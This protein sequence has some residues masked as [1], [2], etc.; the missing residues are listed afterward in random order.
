M[1]QAAIDTTWLEPIIKSKDRTAKQG[2]TDPHS[3]R[4]QELLAF[5]SHEVETRAPKRII[6]VERRGTAIL[7]ALKESESYHLKIPW[8]RVISSSVIEQVPDEFYPSMPLLIFDDMKRKGSH[9][10]HVL[11][12]LVKMDP[13]KALL[14]GVRVAVFAMHEDAST[15][16]EYSDTGILNTWFYRGL[17][18]PAYRNMRLSILSML[19]SAGSLMLDTEHLEVRVRLKRPFPEFLEALGRRAD[20]IPFRSLGGRRNVAVVFRDDDPAHVIP[21]DLLP[22]G[23]RT[24]N[25]VKK[26]RIIERDR[27]RDEYA[28]IPICYPSIPDEL[29]LWPEAPI[30]LFG[31]IVRRSGRA[32]F[33]CAALVAG[34]HVLEW[35]LKGLYAAGEGLVDVVLPISECSESSSKVC[36]LDHLRVMYPT[37]NLDALSKRIVMANKSAMEVGAKLRAHPIEVSPPIEVPS[38]ELRR[39]AWQLL[40]VIRAELDHRIAEERLFN[41]Q[42]SVPHPFGLNAREIFN[43]GDRLDWP[44]V[45]TSALFDILIDDGH[46]VTDAFFD[47]REHCWER[48]YEPDGE[49]V[50][51]LVR[52][53]NTQRGLPI[54]F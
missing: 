12:K 39:R 30:E 17:S 2:R 32:I 49:M 37:V 47:P 5:L 48:V 34:L 27:D 1:N 40:Q 50:S 41:A 35:A 16:S 38:T 10:N 18:T 24:T 14:R 53:Y 45:V 46:L 4:M 51:E 9:I 23:A 7:R 8:D 26:C 42:W 33:Y 28:L 25:I 11:E 43:L 13:T 20:V 22:T 3:L 44:R 6:V 29:P 36:S 15:G 19:Q 52:L 54:G 31:D 21:N